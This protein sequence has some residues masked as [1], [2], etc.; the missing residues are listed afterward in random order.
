[1]TN[2]EYEILSNSKGSL[3]NRIHLLP[4]CTVFLAQVWARWSLNR[5]LPWYIV[6]HS[7]EAVGCKL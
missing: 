2:F 1:M 5:Q 6:R 3:H 7:L 4:L